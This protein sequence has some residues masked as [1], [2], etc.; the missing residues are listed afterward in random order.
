MDFPRCISGTI[1]LKHSSSKKIQVQLLK[2]FPNVGVRGELVYVKPAF[3]RTY[4]HMNN[5][6]CYITEKQGP[7]IPVVEKPR[8]I[9]NDE[10]VEAKEEKVPETKP[11]AEEESNAMSLDELSSLFQ[12]MKNSRGRR[13]VASSTNAQVVSDSV[14]PDYLASELAELLPEVYTIKLSETIQVPIKKEYLSKTI[15]DISGI[16]VAVNRINIFNSDG[17]A[18]DEIS[19]TGDYSLSV[20]TP[21]DRG[22]VRKHIKVQ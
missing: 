14:G 19:S 2:D 5:G 4:L 8:K 16:E 7:R 15:Y 13:S 3:M 17:N 6:A 10:E 21:A 9:I 18:I 11:A 1:R 22:V 12:T 20:N